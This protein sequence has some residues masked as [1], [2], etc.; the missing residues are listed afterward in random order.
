MPVWLVADVL[1]LRNRDYSLVLFSLDK[2]EIN[3]R[4]AE[5]D[6]IDY[7]LPCPTFLCLHRY[8]DYTAQQVLVLRKPNKNLQQ[9]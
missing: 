1:D 4:V 8:M 3:G 2:V 7:H 9:V 5:N 6:C